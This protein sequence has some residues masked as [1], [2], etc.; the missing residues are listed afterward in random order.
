MKI[1]ILK[2]EDVGIHNWP[3]NEVVMSAYQA[4]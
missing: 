1:D 4:I 3:R 2:S